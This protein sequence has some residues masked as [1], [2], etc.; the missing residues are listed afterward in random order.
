MVETL[1]TQPLQ[2]VL[3]GRRGN[4]GTYETGTRLWELAPNPVDLMVIDGAGHYELYDDPRHVDPAVDRLA[5][6]F[7][8]HL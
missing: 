3:A 5:T 7:S 2:V 8:K 1:L 6:F 4:T